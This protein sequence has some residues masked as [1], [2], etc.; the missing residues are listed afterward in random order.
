VDLIPLTANPFKECWSFS[1]ACYGAVAVVEGLAQFRYAPS[2]SLALSGGFLQQIADSDAPAEPV[3][4]WDQA[5]FHPRP[6]AA[7]LPA[8]IHLLPLP[9]DRPELN[10]VEGPWKGYG[11]KRRT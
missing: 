10:P 7:G 1:T 4:I 9:P 8:R 5:G 2:V 6:G 11:S 3:V